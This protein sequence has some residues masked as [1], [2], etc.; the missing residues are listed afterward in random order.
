MSGA[1]NE[2]ASDPKYQRICA[3]FRQQ[4]LAGRLLPGEQLPTHVDIQRQFAAGPMTVQRALTQLSLDGF[5]VAKRGTGTHVSAQ[6]PHLSRFCLVFP[7]PNSADHHLSRFYQGLNDA[8]TALDD[9]GLTKIECYLSV[10]GHADCEDFQRLCDD[11][12]ARRTAGIIFASNPD[13]LAGSIVMD[14]P[15]IPRVALTTMRVPADVVPIRFDDIDLVVQAMRHLAKQ[16]RRRVAILDTP[17]HTPAYLRAVAMA[18]RRAGLSTERRWTIQ[19]EHTSPATARDVTRLLFDAGHR[20]RPDALLITNDNLADEAINGMIEAGV[21]SGDVS[22]V[23]HCNFPWPKPAKLAT[24]RL[25]YDSRQVIDLC[26]KTLRSMRDT[27]RCESPAAVRP[28]FEEHLPRNASRGRR[29]KTLVTD[30][31]QV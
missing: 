17:N 2:T 10:D 18:I 14:E 12:R 22:I 11:V 29:A 25:G 5:T 21:R 24:S 19:I 3:H 23:A 20:E 30:A 16:G 27:G 4:I 6:P 7:A 15:A 13:R 28:I 31:S 9:G 1:P 8:A 26:I